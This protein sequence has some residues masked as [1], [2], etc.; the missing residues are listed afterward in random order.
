VLR[1]GVET[2]ITT[3]SLIMGLFRIWLHCVLR[4]V[5]VFVIQNS[6][7]DVLKKYWVWD[8]CFSWLYILF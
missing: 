4:T 7:Y 8:L 1:A 3:D 5:C 6:F 2:P